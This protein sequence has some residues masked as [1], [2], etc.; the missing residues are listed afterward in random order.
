M[1]I[2]RYNKATCSLTFK[3]VYKSYP[4][5]KKN[6]KKEVF[7]HPIYSTHDPLFS[8]YI[9]DLN[10]VFLTLE[11]PYF[12]KKTFSFISDTFANNFN[13]FVNPDI[14]KNKLFYCFHRFCFFIPSDTN[15]V[16]FVLSRSRICWP[17]T[18]NI[19]YT[20]LYDYLTLPRKEIL[21]DYID[22]IKS[23]AFSPSFS[24]DLTTEDIIEYYQRYNS[25]LD[26]EFSNVL[27]SRYDFLYILD[28][29]Y[30]LKYQA[31]YK[32]KRAILTFVKD[33]LL[34][35]SYD[36]FPISVKTY[37]TLSNASI[38]RIRKYIEYDCLDL[39]SDTL[40]KIYKFPKYIHNLC[41]VTGYFLIP[42]PDLEASIY[43][44]FFENLFLEKSSFK[45]ILDERFYKA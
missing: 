4:Y 22:L 44:E 1:Q 3:K 36:L 18:F 14:L 6:H 25:L 16:E 8:V 11:F 39:P 7:N 37:L 34:H 35:I 27:S 19:K 9:D 15:I 42:F 29:L 40:L 43:K 24:A 5:I 13:L 20:S 12:S 10:N 38:K 31:P 33:T 45:L 21:Q 30:S 2:L 28:Y 23:P 26:H 41:L 17:V 32:Y